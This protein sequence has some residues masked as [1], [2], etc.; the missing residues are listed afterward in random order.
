VPTLNGDPVKVRLAP[1]TPSGRV[2]RVKGRGVPR[3]GQPGDLLAKVNVVVPQKL[4]DEAKAAVEVLR[5]QDGAHDPRA[6]LF[7]KARS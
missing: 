3:K 2:L 1:G 6:E 7:E 5:S 4:S